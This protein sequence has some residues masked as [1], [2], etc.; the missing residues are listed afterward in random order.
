VL[1]V[2]VLTGGP[3][4]LSGWLAERKGYSF[5]ALRA[6]RALP[7]LIAVLVAAV[8][9]RKRPAPRPSRLIVR[10]NGRAGAVVPSPRLRP[11][12]ADNWTG[13]WR[14]FHSYTRLRAP[15]CYAYQVDGAGF[16]DSIVFK[17]A[18]WGS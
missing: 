11:H 14:N 7:P 2:L 10:R 9:P 1:V 8:I 15:G 5:A 17:A 18:V 16:S 13:E 4:V 6:A 3:I 12:G